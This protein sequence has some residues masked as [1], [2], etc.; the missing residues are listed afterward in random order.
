VFTA[1]MGRGRAMGL[2][3]FLFGSPKKLDLHNRVIWKDG[4]FPMEVV[5]E[6]NYQDVLQ[7]ICGGFS[8]HGHDKAVE[9]CLELEPTNPHDAN[10]VRITIAGATVG[11]LPRAQAERVSSFMRSNGFNPLV[12]DALINGGWRTNQHDSGF[13]GVRLG[14]PNR[15]PIAVRRR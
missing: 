12:C 2:L 5:G 11:Y 10:A 15:G 13:F 9:A 3:S 14:V 4:S 7:E 8:R 1:F 6:S